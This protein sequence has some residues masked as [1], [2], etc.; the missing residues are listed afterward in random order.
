MVA[1]TASTADCICLDDTVDVALVLVSFRRRHTQLGTYSEVENKRYGDVS[2]KAEAPATQAA[3][4][5]RFRSNILVVLD[6]RRNSL[7]CEV[8]DRHPTRIALRLRHR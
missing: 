1:L 5:L 6:S 8:D 3:K 2:L 4:A 7:D